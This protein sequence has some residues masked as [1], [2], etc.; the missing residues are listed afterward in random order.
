M[1]DNKGSVHKKGAL[2]AGSTFFL[3]GLQT[4]LWFIL[5]LFIPTHSQRTLALFYFLAQSQKV[6]DGVQIEAESQA[7]V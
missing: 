5:L 4:G 6:F 1:K 3:G 2:H 7:G